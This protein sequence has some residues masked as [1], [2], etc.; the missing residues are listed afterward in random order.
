MRSRK[1]TLI[2]V[3]LFALSFLT[4]LPSAAEEKAKE[5]DL[6]GFP[7]FIKKLM[8]E[9]KVP[10]IA[11]TIVKD[12]KV[13]FAEGFGYRNVTEKLPVTPKTLFAIGSTSK[14]FTAAGMG[15]LVDQGKLDWD[16]PVREYLPSFKLKDDFASQGMTPRDL[17]CHRSGLPRHDFMWIGSSWSRKELFDALRYLEPSEPFRTIFQYQNLMFMTAGYLV[18]L[19]S[20]TSWEEFTRKHIFEPLGMND[21]NFSVE[22]SKKAPDFSLPY[23]E[24][25]D[26][27]TE[28]PF[29]NIDAIGP[30]GAIN[31]NITDMA[32]W[33]KLNLNKG[34]CGDKQVI[35]ETS[36]EEIHSPQMISGRSIQEKEL[37]YSMYGMGWGIT[38]YRGHLYLSHGGGIDGFITQ[39]ALLPD[40]NAGMVIFS[41]LSGNPLPTI[42]AFNIADRILG[43]EPVDWYQRHKDRQ[44][45]AEKEKEKAE[46]EKDADRVMNTCPSH[47]LE[48]YA[49]DYENPGYGIITIEKAGDS[50]K[51][52]YDDMEFDFKHYHYDTFELS[53]EIFGAFG[54]TLKASFSTDKKGNI[55]SIAVPMESAVS[56]IVFTRL[57]DKALSDPE[58]L[59]KF[60]GSYIMEE[61]EE[62]EGSEARV[63]LRGENT[64]VISVP[65]APREFELAP[66]KGTE[67]MLKD[68]QGYS[69]EFLMDESGTVTGA[70]FKTP[71]GTMDLKKK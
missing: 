2:I 9:W 22:D 32:Q 37:F 55:A 30:A 70:R 14:A 64:L 49:G 35:S 50:L 51:G 18:G 45:E 46:K 68:L 31:S 43:L 26:E 36:L 12:G 54:L 67:F 39:V 58:F 71:G 8:E 5:I 53:N 27:V 52:T 34:K 42:I 16:E 69:V 13:I 3:V 20:G 57:P 63:I 25:D 11:V 48:A 15:I 41:N 65:G 23:A 44:E 19:V 47:P 21:S 33:L 28:I 40:E 38:A 10:G 17:V 1:L 66:Y 6:E 62:K 4:W 60:A 59:K 61:E 56:D 24:K 7:E 29:R